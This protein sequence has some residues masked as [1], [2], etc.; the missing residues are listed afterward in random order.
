MDAMSERTQGIR[1]NSELRSRA[2]SATAMR[3]L[4]A[5]E[6]SRVWFIFCTSYT[7]HIL[8]LKG[9]GDSAIQRESKQK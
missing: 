6:V 8:L 5:L 3:I 2:T 4:H 7:P 9:N 1:F